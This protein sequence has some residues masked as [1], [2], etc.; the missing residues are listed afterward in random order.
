QVE[1]VRSLLGNAGRDDTFLV[2]T[3]ATRATPLRAR[4]VRND[5]A[6]VEETLKALEEAHL[7]GA[8]DMGAALRAARPH[9]EAAK[10]PFLV[11]VGGGIPAMGQRQPQKLLEL[12]PK[13][14]RYVGVG[15]GRRW[16][17]ALMQTLAEK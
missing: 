4:A 15:V 7:V 9:L 8:F 17:R 1:L 6:A 10:N 2:L 11:H 3:C 16:E 14:T 12:L 13:G 5:P